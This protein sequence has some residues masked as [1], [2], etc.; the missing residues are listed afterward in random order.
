M[1][2]YLELYSARNDSNLQD[3]VMVAITVAAE[4]IRVDVSPPANQTQREAWASAA[5]ANPESKLNEM[6]WALIAANKDATLNNILEASDASIQTNVDDAV[7]LFAG[8]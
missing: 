4:A 3:K 7:D 2:T 6:M 8:S 1:A 5:L